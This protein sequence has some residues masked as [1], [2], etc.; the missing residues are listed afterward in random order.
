[1]KPIIAERAKEQQI[2][3][4]QSVWQNSA[5]QKPIETRKEIAAIAGVSHDTVSRV[6][7]IIEHPEISEKVKAGELSINQGYQMARRTE[8]IQEVE[9][10]ITEHKQTQTGVADIYNTDK[11]YNIIYADPAWEYWSGGN[12]NQYRRSVYR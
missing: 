4:P 12:K 8:K 1:M 6:E 9:Q 5:E 11:R 3:K 10:R 2:R 7:K